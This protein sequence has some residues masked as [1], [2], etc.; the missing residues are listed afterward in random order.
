M[1]FAIARGLSRRSEFGLDQ[2]A[3][4]GCQEPLKFGDSGN[5]RT[6]TIHGWLNVNA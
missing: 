6:G 5:A 4:K 3:W 1:Y 2:G